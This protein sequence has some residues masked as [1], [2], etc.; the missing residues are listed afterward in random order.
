MLVAVPEFK[1][2]V[3]PTFDFCHKLTLW[4]IDDRGVRAAGHR[5]CK[6]L[7]PQKRAPKL[8][9]LGVD[10]LLCGAIGKEVEDDIRSLGIEVKGGLAGEV[11][12]VISA[13][14]CRA[15]G[16]SRFKMPGVFGQ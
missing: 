13:Y 12:E 15:L 10:L 5:Q 16:E 3:A 4:R 6:G 14:R 9:S 7:A 2:R 1:G 8:K 11:M